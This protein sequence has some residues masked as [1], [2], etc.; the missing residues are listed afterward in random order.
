MRVDILSLF[1]G[2]FDGPLNESILMQAQKK[3]LLNV[4]L[5]DI[6][7]FAEDKH[8]KVDDK[9]YGGGPGMVMKPEPTVKALRSVKKPSSRTIFMS[10]QG[11]PLTAKSCRRLATYDHIVILCGHYEGVDQRIIDAEVDE[12]ISIG[13]FVLTNGCLAALVVLDGMARFITGVVGNPEAVDEE[14]FENGLFDY[15]LYTRPETFEGMEVPSVLK[16]GNHAEITK[17]RRMK[18]LEKTLT[19]RPDLLGEIQS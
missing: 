13:D 15:P 5:V 7:D 16:S 2:Y 11:K 12:E 10:P 8:R 14:T 17:W 6:R 9:V 3:E 1:P 19:T 4:N 18:A